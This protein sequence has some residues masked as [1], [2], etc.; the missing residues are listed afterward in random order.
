MR[1]TFEFQKTE[2]RNQSVYHHHSGHP[3]L[4]PIMAWSSI[5]SRILSHPSTTRQSHVNTVQLPDGRLIQLPNSF[6]ITTVHQSVTILGPQLLGFTAKEVGP[7]SLHGGATMAMY[8]AGTP[9]ST[10]QLTRCWLSDAFMDYIC[11][12]IAKFSSA[13]STTMLSKPNFFT[14]PDHHSHPHNKFAPHHNKYGPSNHIV[15]LN[16][17][18]E[19]HYTQPHNFNSV[20]FFHFALLAGTLRMQKCQ[21]VKLT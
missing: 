8:L 14:I 9:V 1:I 18:L 3:I 4:C 6:L 11:P 7:H 17:V 20:L 5:V 21:G 19:A 13:L 10:I 15:R 12:Q 16:P 2:K